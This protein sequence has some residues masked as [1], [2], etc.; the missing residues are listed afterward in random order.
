MDGI[1]QR[2]EVLEI[3]QNELNVPIRKLAR[4]LAQE[5][6]SIQTIKLETLSRRESLGPS[7]DYIQRLCRNVRASVVG[8]K[9]LLPHIPIP[10]VPQSPEHSRPDTTTS[11]P[12]GDELVPS[13]I[14][15]PA[16]NG[17]LL[18]PSDPPS[19]T[20]SPLPTVLPASATSM[21]T[22]TSVLQNTNALHNE[23]SEQL[24]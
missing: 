13:P 4:R 16:T 19:T 17:L 20:I 14:P 21:A 12:K 2:R 23:L 9:P 18:S 3:L 6:N 10:E 11:L 15:L 5:L 24:A 1:V 8:I 7:E 22:G